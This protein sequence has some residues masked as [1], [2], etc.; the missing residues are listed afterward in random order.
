MIS[1]LAEVVKKKLPRGI[2]VDVL[3][4]KISKVD[5]FGYL[6]E[7]CSMLLKTDRAGSLCHDE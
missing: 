7:A 1:S 3:F 5:V 6:F 4:G 2:K